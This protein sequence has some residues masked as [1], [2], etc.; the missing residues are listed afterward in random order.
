HSSC[1]STAKC[2]VEATPNAIGVRCCKANK[3]SIHA[4]IE[5]AT[6]FDFVECRCSG[7]A[8]SKTSNGESAEEYR[9]FHSYLYPDV[10]PLL[11]A[12]S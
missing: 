6:R 4:A 9:F 1:D 8:R 11:R 5:T 10:H 12:K 7:S 2:Y 3:A